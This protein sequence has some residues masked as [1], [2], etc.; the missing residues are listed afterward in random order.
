MQ[1]YDLT[2]CG[3]EPNFIGSWIMEPT[4]LSD[5]LVDYFENHKEKQTLGVTG[6]GY[7]SNIKDSTDISVSP[8]DLSL[9]GNEIFEPYFEN[10]FECFRD[11]TSQWPFLMSFIKSLEISPFNLQRYESGQHFRKTHSERSS[12]ASLHRVFAW[13]TYL[14][15]VSEEDGGATVFTHYNLSIQPKKGLTLIWPAE[16][17]HAHRGSVMNANVKHIIT[18]WMHF[19]NEKN[20]DGHELEI[21]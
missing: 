14:N 21:H 1:R 6:S 7:S 8:K 15:D 5:N 13:M 3:L 19:P 9:P 11:Y 18:G 4:S 10:L 16:W 2:D 12:L 20:S 17:T